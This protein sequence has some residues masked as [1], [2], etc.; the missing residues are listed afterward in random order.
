MGK[1]IA[2]SNY[3]KKP[4]VLFE[5]KVFESDIKMS[6]LKYISLGNSYF[7][8]DGLVNVDEEV[9]IKA[10]EE[11]FEILFDKEAYEKTVNEN[12]EIGKKFYSLES[13]QKIIQG[14]LN[15]KV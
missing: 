2:R 14:I 9:E 3:G 5:Y 1:S 13:L 7:K 15:D 8:K 11:L 6:G 10:A 4:I 12:F